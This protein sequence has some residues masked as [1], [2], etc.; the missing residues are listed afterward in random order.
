MAD[1]GPKALLVGLV[2]MVMG[3]LASYVTS[4]VTLKCKPSPGGHATCTEGRLV[5]A[6]IDIPLREL[7]EVLGAENEEQTW[8]DEGTTRR[9]TEPTLLTPAGREP[10]LFHGAGADFFGVVSRVDA[11]AKDPRPEG[12]RVGGQA[13]GTPFVAHLFALLVVLA[14]LS[15]VAGVMRQAFRRD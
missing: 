12:L 11:Y 7:P 4:G 1:T 6:V 5:L 9:R 10:F 2:A 14:G 15:A 3:G 8:N 13:S